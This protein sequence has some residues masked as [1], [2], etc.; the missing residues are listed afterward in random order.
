MSRRLTDDPLVALFEAFASPSPIPGGG[1]AAAVASGLGVS[2]LRMAATLPRTRTESDDELAAVSSV[3]SALA[4]LQRQLTETANDDAAAYTRVAAAY[5]LPK[6]SGTEQA[7]R[8]SSIQAS[9]RAATEVPLAIMRLSAGALTHARTV[10]ARRRRAVASDV[11]VAIAL[12]RAGTEGAS[13]IVRANLTALSDRG[14]ADAAGVEAS[15]L[16]EQ[17]ATAATAAEALLDL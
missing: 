3:A 15:S 1:S 14:Y 11:A 5:K 4:G 16:L 7:S 12:L 10:A 13:R 17:A 9:L 8:E 2:L 6:S